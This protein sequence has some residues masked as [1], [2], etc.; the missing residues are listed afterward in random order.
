MIWLSGFIYFVLFFYTYLFFQGAILGPEI[1]INRPK[2]EWFSIVA[3]ALWPIFWVIVL[4]LLF[5][6]LF[7]KNKLSKGAEHE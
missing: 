3:G 1:R 4:M 2:S 7:I 5:G 6:S